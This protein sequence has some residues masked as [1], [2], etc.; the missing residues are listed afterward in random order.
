MFLHV[1]VILF[2]GGTRSLSWGSPSQGVSVFGGLCP[3]GLCPGGCLCPGGVFVWGSLSSG[4]SVT[5]TPVR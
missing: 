1:S 2:T 4:V 3:G 5:E